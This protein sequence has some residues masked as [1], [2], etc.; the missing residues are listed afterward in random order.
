MAFAVWITG[1]P[2]SGKS[3]I[4]KE[5][6][7]SITVEILR[8]D[9][10]RKYILPEKKYLKKTMNEKELNLT[11]R[12][13]AVIACFLVKNGKNVVIDSTDSTGIGRKLARKLIK[14]FFVVQIKCPLRIC[15]KRE[16]E[17]EDK[18]GII[19][20]YKRVRAEKIRIPGFGKKYVEEKKPLALINSNKVSPQKAASAVLDRLKSLKVI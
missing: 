19:N 5:L 18:A 12:V 1:V 15:E 13:L 14:D 17:R 2:G 6:A 8:L 7:K 10:I 20:L 16:A 9:D 4:A 3:T 11:Y